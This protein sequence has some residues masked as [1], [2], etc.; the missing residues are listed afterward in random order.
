MSVLC[1]HAC[2]GISLFRD[3]DSFNLLL[4]ICVQIIYKLIKI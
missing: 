4:I 1:I 3:D 2:L